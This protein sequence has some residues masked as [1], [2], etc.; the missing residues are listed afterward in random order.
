MEENYEEQGE[1]EPST[2]S[3]QRP[4]GGGIKNGIKN[5]A[6]KAGNAIKQSVKRVW[7]RIPIKYRL[8]IIGLLVALIIV[9]FLAV[10]LLS[11]AENLKE[12]TEGNVSSYV[13]S[14][15]G[16]VAIDDLNPDNEWAKDAKELYD[17]YGSLVLMKIDDI[18]NIYN[19]TIN[20]S[21]F[22]A[23]TKKILKKVM[24]ENKLKKD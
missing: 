9:I 13:D 10:V 14:S 21:N 6:S 22:D 24:G 18:N 3:D 16:K 2:S 23:A 1:Q 4:S 7:K 19:K 12:H 5:A 17:K 11:K 15:I 8:I 20:D